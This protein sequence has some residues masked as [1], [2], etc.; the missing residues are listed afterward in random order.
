MSVRGPLLSQ[1]RRRQEGALLAS[2]QPRLFL[3]GE[4]QTQGPEMGLQE[5]QAALWKEAPFKSPFRSPP[6]LYPS[7]CPT[8]P[9]AVNFGAQ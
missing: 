8:P 2:D 7:P 5:G 1:P 3:A 4:V 6:S 9:H